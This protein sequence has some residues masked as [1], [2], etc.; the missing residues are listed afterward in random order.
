MIQHHNN[1]N[2]N[3]KDNN[4]LK[5]SVVITVHTKRFVPRNWRNVL[6]KSASKISFHLRTPICVQMALAVDAHL[7]VI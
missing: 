7:A 1:N 6:N 3:N 5:T 2:N 4:N